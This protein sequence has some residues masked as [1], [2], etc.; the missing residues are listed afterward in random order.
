MPEGEDKDA[1]SVG[2]MHKSKQLQ[3]G[4]KGMK[5]DDAICDS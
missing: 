4:S 1:K 2:Y 3:H 5:I